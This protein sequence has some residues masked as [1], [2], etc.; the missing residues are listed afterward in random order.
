MLSG[1]LSSDKM[2][3][4]THRAWQTIQLLSVVSERTHAR[5]HRTT[6]NLATQLS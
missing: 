5:L 2:V 3:L 4:P 6:Q 1:L